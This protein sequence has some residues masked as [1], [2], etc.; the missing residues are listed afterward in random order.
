MEDVLA[1]SEPMYQVNCPNQDLAIRIMHFDQLAQCS[2]TAE[3]SD[4]KPWFY[5][6]KHYLEKQ[7][8]SINA[9][10]GDK[11]TLIRLATKFFLNEDVFYKRNYDSFL[12]KFMDRHESYILIKEIHEGGY[13]W[14]TMETNYFHYAKTCHQFHIYA[15]KVHIQLL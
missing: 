7:E 15:D 10:D 2:S 9:S 4:D 6:I 3:E 14:L 5:D 13:Y 12:L 8:Y 1:T 11:Q